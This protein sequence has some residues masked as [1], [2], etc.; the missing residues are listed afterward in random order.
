MV[1]Y[2][3]HIFFAL[4]MLAYV[5]VRVIRARVPDLSPFIRYYLTDL[6]FVPAMGLFALIVIRWQ[7]KDARLLIPWYAIAVQVVLVSMYFEW[8]LPRNTPEGHLHVTD[9]VDCLMYACGGVLFFGL[10]RLTR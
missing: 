2:R 7:R 1:K 10:Q 8:Y 3:A 4:I 6:L 5:V 9:T